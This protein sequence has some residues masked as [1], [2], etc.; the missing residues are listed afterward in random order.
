VLDRKVRLLIRLRGVRSQSAVKD[1]KKG[2]RRQFA[3]F[4]PSEGCY[5]GCSIRSHI[6]VLDGNLQ[7]SVT[8]RGA[9]PQSAV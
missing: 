2:V 6:G 8:Y 4:D 5:P 7:H 9:I 1:P 3:A